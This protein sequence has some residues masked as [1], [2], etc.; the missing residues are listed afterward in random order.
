M[1]QRYSQY[2]YT[3]NTNLRTRVL[4][5][6]FWTLCEYSPN[7]PLRLLQPKGRGGCAFGGKIER[8]A[9]FWNA[10]VNGSYCNFI[11]ITEIYPSIC[12]T[13][14]KLILGLRLFTCWGCGFES[15]RGH[16]CLS[17]VSVVCCQV[18]VS[19]SGWLLVQRSPT[20]CGLS[21]ECDREAPSEES[22]TRNWVEASQ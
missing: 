10:N 7:V 16:E 1:L 3:N 6:S 12:K 4:W 20:V 19:A 14:A 5:I 18:Q 2:L 22:M 17:L 8:H 21:N 13:Y 9:T 11:Q 15:P